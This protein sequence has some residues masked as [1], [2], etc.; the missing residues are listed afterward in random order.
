MKLDTMTLPLA[1]TSECDVSPTGVAQLAGD[2]ETS[3][4]EM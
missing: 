2:E 4:E 1:F 3:D